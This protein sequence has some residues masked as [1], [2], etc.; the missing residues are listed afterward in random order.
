MMLIKNIFLLTQAIA[1]SFLF[2][3]KTFLKNQSNKSF[4]SRNFDKFV[5]LNSSF[6][7]INNQNY[8]NNK[9]NKNILITNFVH[10]PVY[11]YTE[12]LI[13]KYI[14]NFYDYNIFGLID[15]EDEFGE[16]LIKSFNVDNFF[17]YP[18]ISMFQRCFFLLKAFKIINNLKTIDQFI[19]LSKGEVNFGRCVYDHLIRNTGIASFNKINFKFYFFLSDALFCN[20]FCINLFSK[21]KFEYMIMSET[22]FLP[23]NIIFQHALKKK[24]KVISRVEGTKKIGITLVDSIKDKYTSNNKIKKSSI[25]K[26]YIEDRK[27]FSDKGL[28]AI[29]KIFYNKTKHWDVFSN[30]NFIKSNNLNADD[31]YNFLNWN[32]SQKTCVIF[33][34]N[35]LDGNYIE[36]WRIF[37]DNLTWLR[38]TLM[39]IK[40]L[41]PEINWLYKEHPSEYGLKFSHAISSITVFNEIIGSQDNIKIFPKKF[42]TILLKDVAN[43]V[44]T[45]Q[46]SAGIEYPCFGTP[47]ITGGDS[48]YNGLGFSH[49]PE[50]K[51]QYFSLLANM[52][53]IAS[54]KLT[55]DQVDLARISF[56]FYNKATKLDHPLLDD[57]EI[58]KESDFNIFFD[59]SIDLI[60]KYKEEDDI[61]KRRLK[62]QL[63]NIDRH[64][65]VI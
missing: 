34:H 32:K 4:I 21:N 35:L 6:W 29:S 50:N 44:L 45:S 52:P 57:Y 14:Q 33:G 30:K 24:I 2:H 27:L 31:L 1:Y 8:S 60:S 37:R 11:T 9:D 17:Y 12:L 28:D 56:Y 59:K 3:I 61:F 15:T 18:N 22:Q 19:N 49:N 47:S 51:D 16:K 46:G 25:E 65:T 7:K 54:K 10:Q 36:S 63:E 38:E 41:N 58:T 23:S 20:N 13:S 53:K 43:C 26:L 40:N 48:F 55:P 64:L 42:N 62:I 5:K 39:F